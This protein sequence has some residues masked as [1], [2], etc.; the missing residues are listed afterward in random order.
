[1]IDDMMSPPITITFLYRP[2]STNCCPVTNAYKKPEHA[3][4]KSYPH[5]FVAPLL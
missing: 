4:L 1:M 3:A 2:D 5:A